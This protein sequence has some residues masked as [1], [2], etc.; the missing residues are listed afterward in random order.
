MDLNSFKEANT[1]AEVYS[2]ARKLKASGFDSAEVNNYATQRK[3]EL[4]FMSGKVNS[5]NK[6]VPKSMDINRSKVSRFMLDVKN[7]NSG[8]ITLTA[9]NKV[10]I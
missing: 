9:D 5:L 4:V 7:L 3:K 10:I 1:I 2:L 6:V 8:T